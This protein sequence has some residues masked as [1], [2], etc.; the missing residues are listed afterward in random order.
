MNTQYFVVLA[1]GF[2]KDS[3]VVFSSHKTTKAAERAAKPGKNCRYVVRK[4]HLKK[5]DE[6]LRCNEGI[7]PC[8]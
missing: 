4:G 3:A 6:M 8:I 5:G 7:Y 2:Y 1:P